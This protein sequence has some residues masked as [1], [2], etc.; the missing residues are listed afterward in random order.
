MSSFQS[1]MQ[2]ETV[3]GKK[4]KP[5][6]R[7]QDAERRQCSRKVAPDTQRMGSLVEEFK[8]AYDLGQIG[9]HAMWNLQLKLAKELALSAG[10]MLKFLDLCTDL[11]E[12]SYDVK[13]TMVPGIDALIEGCQDLIIDEGDGEVWEKVEERDARTIGS[14]DS[15]L[16]AM[17]RVVAMVLRDKRWIKTEERYEI[18]HA[19]RSVFEAVANLVHSAT[20]YGDSLELD[21]D[22]EALLDD[23]VGR[24]DDQTLDEYLDVDCEKEGEEEE[25]EEEEE[26]DDDDE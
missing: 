14:L 5:N 8:E 9:G 4:R 22:L 18:M 19:C 16:E 24:C 11:E 21:D 15:M 3:T 10:S 2:Q 26:E 23:A 13:E 17:Q 6:P 12:L 1:R 25:E 7:I 20:Y